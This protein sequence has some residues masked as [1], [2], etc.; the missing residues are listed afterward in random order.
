LIWGCADG[1]ALTTLSAA[2]YSKIVA[3]N[4]IVSIFGANISAGVFTAANQGSSPLPTSLGGVTAS[5]TDASG[6]TLP[7]SLI[8]VTPGQVNAVLPSGLQ[9]GQYEAELSGVLNLTTA[10]G[11]KMTGNIVLGTVAP[12][13][14]TSDQTGG[15]LAAAQ[16]V[17]AHADGSQTFMGSIATCGNALV[18]DGMTWSDC[19]PIPINL[20]STTDQVV[21]ELFGT[22][23]RGANSLAA[24]CQGCGYSAVRVMVGS[25]CNPALCLTTYLQVLYAGSQG[26]GGPGSFPGLDQVNVALP[27][28]MAGAGT[29]ALTLTALAGYLTGAGGAILAGEGADANTVYV[30]I[31]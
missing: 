19:V 5:V 11:A 17:I 9:S 24:S 23:I 16:V 8:A 13:L 10:S 20:G 2:N 4:S 12:S 29:V 15:W 26:A 31:K 22:G 7:V 25:S 27:Y 30:N 18:F 21:L 28:S 6:N 1:Q 3:P 14:F